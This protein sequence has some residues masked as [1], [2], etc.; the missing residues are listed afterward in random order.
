MDYPEII[1][2]FDANI[3]ALSSQMVQVLTFYH[4]DVPVI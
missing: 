3:P 4:G 1:R 2:I